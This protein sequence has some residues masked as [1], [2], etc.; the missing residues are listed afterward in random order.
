MSCYIRKTLRDMKKF[1][2]ICM[3]TASV[4][5]AQTTYH[6]FDASGNW[7][8]NGGVSNCSCA[9]AAGASNHIVV[10][11]DA[12]SSG[13]TPPGTGCHQVTGGTLQ[14]MASVTV[15][16]GG[17][18]YVSS[19]FSAGNVFTLQDITVNSGGEMYVNGGS[20]YHDPVNLT[21]NGTFTQN[22]GSNFST[23]NWTLNGTV[24]LI[25]SSNCQ[26]CDITGTGSFGACGGLN[27]TFSG[28]A[29]LIN[30]VDQAGNDVCGVPLPVEYGYFRAHRVNS[31]IELSWST[32]TE[33]NNRE[34]RIERSLDTESFETIGTISGSINSIETINYDFLDQTAPNATVYYRIT[35]VDVDGRLSHS[36]IVAVE[37]ADI[38]FGIFPNPARTSITILG[39][40]DQT[41]TLR[42]SQ[43]LAVHY[44][45][46]TNNETVINVSDLLSG[47]YSVTIKGATINHVEKLVIVH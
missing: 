5:Q 24:N 39:A 38:E 13:L 6:T 27:A 40:E 32:L 22:G 8:T 46:A 2:W 25:G 7:S 34:F 28:T 18:F 41:I 17:A 29:P 12:C 23:N 33:V 36:R 35:Q 1:I 15:N 21:M 3:L 20:V 37:A 16:S 26:G 42:D 43:G 19:A 14:S 30:G 47:V 10:N 45:I 11:H 9:P 44:S 31:G 4:A